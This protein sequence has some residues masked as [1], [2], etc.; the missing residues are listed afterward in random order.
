[1][2][3]RRIIFSFVNGLFS[4]LRHYELERAFFGN[5]KNAFIFNKLRVNGLWMNVRSTRW[6]SS[7]TMSKRSTLQN[8]SNSIIIIMNE[9]WAWA[10]GRSA[11]TPFSP[12]KIACSQPGLVLPLKFTIFYNYNISTSHRN[13]MW[14]HVRMAVRA[15]PARNRSTV[16]VAQVNNNND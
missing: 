13:A 2:L 3:L 9:L 10:L 6:T 15:G 8:S 11:H 1:M 12:Y 16:L 7:A 14:I 5:W 4:S